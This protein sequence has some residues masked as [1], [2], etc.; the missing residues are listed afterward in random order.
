MCLY[1]EAEEQAQDRWRPVTYA[2]KQTR[3][4]T[5]SMK[6]LPVS[7]LR[8]CVC[9]C[10]CVVHKREKWSVREGHVWPARE[11]RRERGRDR[12]KE[13]GI[14]REEAVSTREEG[15]SADPK[16]RK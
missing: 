10:V 3:S 4:S 8:V 13:G 1:M 5:L 2:P 6:R 12:E 14:G 9:V 16:R 15:E 7:V 11:R